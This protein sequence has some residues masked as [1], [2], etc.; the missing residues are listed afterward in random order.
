MAPVVDE[1]TATEPFLVDTKSK[2]FDVVE[3]QEWIKV[4]G[5]IVLCIVLIVKSRA[6]YKLEGVDKANKWIIILAGF[7]VVT[8]G[9]GFI[10]IL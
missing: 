7:V 8:T 2:A 10:A 3:G 4:L 5:A 9:I 6:V 1:T